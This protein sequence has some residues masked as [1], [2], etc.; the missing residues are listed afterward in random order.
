MIEDLKNRVIKKAQNDPR[1]RL[2]MLN[3]SRANLHGDVDRFSDLDIVYYVVDYESVV[4]DQHFFD[5]F[6]NVLISQAKEE[7]L[8][9]K[10]S[11]FLGYIKMMQFSNGT[12]LDL[13]IIDVCDLTLSL[14]DKDYYQPLLD[15]DHRLKGQRLPNQ[16]VFTIDVPTKAYFQA[17]VKEFYWLSLYV[18]K[19]L[20]RS[21][22]P[23]AIEHL[24]LMRAA[25]EAMLAWSIGVEY[26]WHI[27][28]GKSGKN[29]PNYLD[30][31]HYQTY[32]M[33]YPLAKKA[34]VYESLF[35]MVNLYR[36]VSEKVSKHFGYGILVNHQ[37]ICEYIQ[38]NRR[39]N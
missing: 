24:S 29:L 31:E 13:S 4:N 16:N 14:A 19:G 21:M 36:V 30:K 34:S 5:E 23:Y 25:L 28:L 3:G 20:E 26:G 35:T 38:K 15:K 32:L 12:R 27:E 1:V 33:T 18:M 6:E 8:F 7:Q 11:E 17:N 22:I 37:A 10:T 9:P 2:V 39:K